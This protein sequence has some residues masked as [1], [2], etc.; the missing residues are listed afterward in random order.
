MQGQGLIDSLSENLVCSDNNMK[1]MK[2][3]LLILSA[4]SFDQGASVSSGQLDMDESLQAAFWCF[5]S[6]MKVIYKMSR[7]QCVELE[8]VAPHH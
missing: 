7:I 6:M 5:W 2:T 1:V 4:C 3:T 8:V